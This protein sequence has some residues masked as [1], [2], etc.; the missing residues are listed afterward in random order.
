M[1]VSVTALLR[2]LLPCP[3][4]LHRLSRGG[5]CWTF[6]ERNE[7]TP[8]EQS[9][10]RG[11]ALTSFQKKSIL[12]SLKS[13]KSYDHG[14][15]IVLFGSRGRAP[16]AHHPRHWCKFVSISSGPSRTFTCYLS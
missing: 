6:P 8:L 2:P 4:Q 10:V 3:D 5:W 16:A 7:A 9:S 13:D 14:S 1:G 12:Q 11:V 15:P